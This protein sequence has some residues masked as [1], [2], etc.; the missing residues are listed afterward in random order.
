MSKA[1]LAAIDGAAESA[2]RS[3][4]DTVRQAFINGIEAGLDM[5]RASEPV[6]EWGFTP[7]AAGLARLDELAE[8]EGCTRDEVA[9][10]VFKYGAFKMPPG[11]TG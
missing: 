4:S 6:A 11:Y 1:E 10:R 5:A 7:S 8:R 9:R 3:R 2:S